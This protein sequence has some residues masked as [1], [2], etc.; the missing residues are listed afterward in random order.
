VKRRTFI[1]VLGG[2]AAW[3]LAARAQQPERMRR[4]GV[5]MNTA[6]SNAVGQAQLAAFRQRL[7]ELGWT[8][9]RNVR[10]DVRWGAGNAAELVGLSPDVL[11]AYASAQLTALARE[12][13]AIPIVF[14]GAS[15]PVGAGFVASF[16]RPGGN[17]TGFTTYEPSLG[18]KWL[19]TLKE[20][21]PATVRAALMVN[22]DITFLQGRTYVPAF[23]SAAAALSVEPVTA[24][25]RSTGD[26]EAA[27]DSLGQRPGGGLIVV[28]ESF[29]STHRELIVRLAAQ[30]R[31]PA[32]YPYR[33]FPASGGLISY[34]PDNVD[35]FRRSAAYIDRIMRGEEPA[36]LPVQ[37]QT[38]FELV[39]NLKT[40]KALGLKVLESFLVRADE[41]IE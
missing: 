37:A 25:V 14:I 4:V 20:I 24:H 13:R 22:P 6:E 23:E 2:V 5:V 26:I 30:H 8:E 28:P 39:I 19:A 1:T 29:T 27:L 38:K 32:M 7:Q 11:L 16:A 41:V 33:Q 35:T 36:D 12:T 9:G 21:A 18:G 10:I 40:A 15:D 31:V 17:I 3:P 34:G